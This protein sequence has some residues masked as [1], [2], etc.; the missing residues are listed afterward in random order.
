M[1]IE[2]MKCKLC[3][4]PTSDEDVY[5]N[6]GGRWICLDCGVWIRENGEEL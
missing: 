2:N 4:K 6:E 3:K 1:K 5:P